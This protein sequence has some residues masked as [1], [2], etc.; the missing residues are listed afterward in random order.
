MTKPRQ[1]LD[2]PSDGLAV[3]TADISKVPRLASELEDLYE[4]VPSTCCANSGE[5]CVLTEKE[6]EE[7]YATMFP[8]YRA[9]YVNIVNYVRDNFPHERQQQLLSLTAERP[10][11][12]PFL[13]EDNRCTIYPVRPLICRTYAVMNQDTI[14]EA[15][16]RHQGEVPEHWIRSFVM[17]E[18]NMVC[19]RVTVLQPEKLVRHAHNLLT[20][21][22]ERTLTSLSRKVELATGSRKKLIR[23][24]IRRRSWP[25]RWTWGG[26]NTLRFAPLN[27]LQSTLKSYWQRSELSQAD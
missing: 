24:T 5:C 27:W 1:E 17:R 22:Y 11:R 12:C 6:I 13:A 4:Q 21:T 25:V 14:A 20:L 26:F 2:P 15:A 18:G 16:Q 10:Q 9:E 19:P 8:L 3:D 7:G 23:E